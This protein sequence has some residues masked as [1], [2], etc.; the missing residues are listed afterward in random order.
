MATLLDWLIARYPSAKRQ[1]FKHMLSAGRISI[2]GHR[3]A[4][5]R[6]SVSQA[7]RVTVSDREAD[8]VAPPLS[9]LP[10]EMVFEDCDVLVID[11]PPGLLTS[12]NERERRPTAWAAVQ[13]YLA[14]TD[15]PA[16]PGLIHR[17]DRDASGPSHFL[18]ERRCLPPS[19]AAVSA[20]HRFTNLHRSRARP[21]N[22]P[23]GATRIA[24]G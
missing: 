8:R 12:T 16:R 11:K 9:K 21:S 5:L 2:N 13:H 23:R 3:P 22:T 17:L 10:F 6:V 15:P 24:P 4:S 20:S 14:A 18:E 7:D 19:Q 1:T